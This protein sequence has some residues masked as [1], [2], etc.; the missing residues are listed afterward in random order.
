[1]KRRISWNRISDLGI[2]ETA[3]AELGQQLFYTMRMVA[4]K[5]HAFSSIKGIE[6]ALH[7]VRQWITSGKEAG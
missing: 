4:R 7:S 6:K 1:M 2:G 5:N 3:M